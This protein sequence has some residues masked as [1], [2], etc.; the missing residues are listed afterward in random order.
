MDPAVTEGRFSLYDSLP[1]VAFLVSRGLSHIFRGPAASLG[2][3]QE[4]IHMYVHAIA[5]SMTR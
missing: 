4:D 1:R 2:G 3:E 5:N